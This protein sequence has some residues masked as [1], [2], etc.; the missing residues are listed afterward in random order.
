MR[1][2]LF[3]KVVNRTYQAYLHIHWKFFLNTFICTQLHRSRLHLV[4]QRCCDLLLDL[5]YFILLLD[6]TLFIASCEYGQNCFLP[7]VTLE[8]GH[9]RILRNSIVLLGGQIGALRL[10]LPEL[11]DPCGLGLVEVQVLLS[12]EEGLTHIHLIGL[13]IASRVMLEV[14]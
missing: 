11:K 6:I 4:E 9:N 2:L 7:R 13:P 12:V 10:H 14:N 1:Q 3:Y 5:R 8:R